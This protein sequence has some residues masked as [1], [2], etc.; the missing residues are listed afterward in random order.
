MQ[1]IMVRA[2]MTGAAPHFEYFLETELQSQRKQQDYDTD[3]CPNVDTARIMYRWGINEMR[4][5]IKPATIY[6]K[7]TGCFNHLNK[8]ETTAAISKIN[9][10]S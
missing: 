6:P 3:L 9:A 1:N 10:K 4:P 7:T 2:A 5:A 8:R